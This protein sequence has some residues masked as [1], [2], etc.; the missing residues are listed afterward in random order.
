MLISHVCCLHTQ[1]ANLMEGVE[2]SLD[3]W[4]GPI[5]SYNSFAVLY[6]RF[7]IELDRSTN[8]PLPDCDGK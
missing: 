3:F 8:G 6:N 7:L 1:E 2:E 5:Q 4:S